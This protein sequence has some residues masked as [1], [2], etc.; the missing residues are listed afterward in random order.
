MTFTDAFFS[1][2][3]FD[4]NDSLVHLVDTYTYENVNFKKT[5]TWIDGTTIDDTK[6]DGIIYRKKMDSAGNP[7]Y[8]VRTDVLN[9]DLDVRIFGVQANDIHD[10]TTAL[11]SAFNNACRLGLNIVLPAGTMKITQGLLLD[12]SWQETVKNRIQIIGKG[13]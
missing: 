11:Q 5:S 10:D 12:F 6:V 4:T 13:L 3:N 1:A 8:Y 9:G 7:F 2:T